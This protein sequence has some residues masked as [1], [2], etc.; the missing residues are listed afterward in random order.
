MRKTIKKAVKDVKTV[1]LYI[2]DESGSMAQNIDETISG[3]NEYVRGIKESKLA[4]NIYMS[5][6]KFN[7]KASVL[8]NLVPIAE[9][10]E[11]TKENYSPNG[12]TALYDS[13]G[14][15]VKAFEDAIKTKK[16]GDYKV[17]AM[18]M[19]DG[20]ENAST[21]YTQQAIRTI[22]DEKQKLGNWTFTYLGADQSAWTTAQGIGIAHGNTISNYSGRGGVV[23]NKNT[24]QRTLSY[25]SGANSN[26]GSTSTFLSGFDANNLESTKDIPE[27]EPLKKDVKIGIDEVLRFVPTP[28][29]YKKIESGKKY[30]LKDIFG[31]KK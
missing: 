3:F 10:P 7:T 19:T 9:I 26:I 22:I 6:A 8:H 16:L 14:I 1:V 5:F 11:L 20:R 28:K 31:K 30:K 15:T 25:A 29:K 4:K 24:R 21:E 27:F 13:I 12:W 17:L 18:V 23:V 2:I